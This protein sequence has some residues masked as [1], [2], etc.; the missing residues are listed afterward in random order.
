MRAYA[1]RE[2][3]KAYMRAYLRKWRSKN[4]GKMRA[5][6]AKWREANPT[7]ARE[8]D[9]KKQKKHYASHPEYRA[10]AVARAK[11]WMAQNPE[12]AKELRSDVCHRRRARKYATMVGPIDY[13]QL[14]IQANGLCGICLKPLE[15][16]KTEFDHIIPLARGGSHTQNN[17]QITHPRCNR[18][19]NSRLPE[20]RIVA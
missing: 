10:K 2:A 14:F 19:K 18:V 5:Y 7:I 17:L 6:D 13:K 20:E 15:D 4:P 3:R 11:R 1:H 9:K 16:S 8:S 12:R